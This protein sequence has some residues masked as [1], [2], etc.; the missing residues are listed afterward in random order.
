MQHLH[1]KTGKMQH[2]IIA[3]SLVFILC[4]TLFFSFQNF[5]QRVG[6]NGNG[7][8]ANASAAFDIDVSAMPGMKTGLLI[9]RVTE[10]ERVAMSPL[11]EAAP[12]LIVYQ[13]DGQPGFY[14]NTSGSVIPNWTAVVSNQSLK[15]NVLQSATG[16]LFLDNAA[17]T[18]AFSF[19][20]FTT[21]NAFSLSTNTVTSGNLLNLFSN[22]TS[23]SANTSS[24]MLNI[25][26]I[27]ANSNNG[28]ISTGINVTISSTGNS[29][30][31]YGG[32]FLTS[33]ASTNY[34]IYSRINGAGTAVYARTE[35]AV[36][37]IGY[38]LRS[39]ITGNAIQNYA[40]FFSAKDATHNYAL[41]VPAN[42]GR[43][44]FGSASSDEYAMLSINNG[45]FQA[46]QTVPPTIVAY[47]NAGI[48]SNVSLKPGSSDVAGTFTII[49]GGAANT[50]G[51]QAI[52]TFNKPFSNNARVIL[53]P[54]SFQ[55][56]ARQFF[57]VSTSTTFFIY[58]LQAALPNTEYTYNYIVM[59]N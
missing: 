54:A 31:N 28:H 44:S 36:N 7:A 22:S 58:F 46:Q 48:L 57:V 14:Y 26:R 6:I 9:P 29:S 35:S 8:A 21:G 52:I 39:E 5:A 12:G 16:N 32:N 11:P 25:N 15:W 40:G 38:G 51:E 1:F 17:N 53:T 59:D 10:A 30:I 55:A 50:P 24:R 41:F 33:G 34:G 18:T 13:T 3:R 45:H 47:P 27:G 49:S 2:L 20:G 4:A 23:G 37:G 43:V 42:S 19:N 56:A